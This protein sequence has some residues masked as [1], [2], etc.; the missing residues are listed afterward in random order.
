MTFKYFL[1]TMLLF[2]DNYGY[3]QRLSKSETVFGTNYDVFVNK[4]KLHLETAFSVK[5]KETM[6]FTFFEQR[7]C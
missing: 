7:N 2:Q 1:V 4:Q 3:L 5:I 6:C